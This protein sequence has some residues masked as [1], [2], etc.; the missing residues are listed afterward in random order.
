M[1]A[2]AAAGTKAQLALGQIH[3]VIDHD[4]LVV[5]GLVPVA[6][7]HHALAGEV[8]KGLG[9]AERHPLAANDSLAHR[10]LAAQALDG[11][12]ILLGQHL[13]HVEAHIVAGVLVFPARIAQANDHIHGISSRTKAH[14]PSSNR[15]TSIL[16]SIYGHCQAL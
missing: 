2:R 14:R 6:Q 7:L 8:H 11:D 10:R 9:L 16:P 12:V 4:Q 13:G 15:L 1:G 3:V 5:L